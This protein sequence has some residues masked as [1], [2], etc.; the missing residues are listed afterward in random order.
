[1][2]MSKCCCFC[3]KI[4]VIFLCRVEY[5]IILVEKKVGDV[6]EIET[7][8]ETEICGFNAAEKAANVLN[9][10]EDDKKVGDAMLLVH[11]GGRKKHGFSVAE[12]VITR[13]YL[14][15]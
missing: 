10:E 2:T 14:F 4:D 9:I 15:I 5:L 8:T 6:F 7:M 3:T 1:M 11:E 12:F 13:I